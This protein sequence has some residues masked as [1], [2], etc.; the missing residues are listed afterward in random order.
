MR[1][2]L[3][4]AAAV[5]LAAVLP[6]AGDR[7]SGWTAPADI[8]P[9]EKGACAFL[10][11][12]DSEMLRQGE[13][14]QRSGDCRAAARFYLFYLSRNPRDS[15]VLYNLACCYAR[16]GQA[17]T[18]VQVLR[19]ALG[20]GFAELALLER[21]PDFTSVR[22]T[23]EFRALVADLPAKS[24]LSGAALW[25]Q[26]PRLVQCR[27]ALPPGYS[28]SRPCPLVIGLHGNGGNGRDFLALM[29]PFLRAGMICVA[30]D[31]PYERPEMAGY[32]A[33]FTWFLPVQDKAVWAVADPLSETYIVNAAETFAKRFHA[34][35][36]YLL[37]FSQGA[38]AAI[39]TGVHHWRKFAGVACFGGVSLHESLS[40]TD[41][42]A[43]SR[44]R[45]FIGHG[46]ADAVSAVA[47]GRA[48]QRALS[49]AGLDVRYREFD[50]GHEVPRRLLDE[51]IEWMGRGGQR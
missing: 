9:L 41:I 23:R 11:R 30:P 8:D 22:D 16:L 32:G 12:D 46:N 36:V 44:L 13:T 47:N 4:L 48:N 49:A 7:V 5:L 19:H 28:A 25:V 3:F 2:S 1:R 17:A 39:D 34:S 35:A 21:D 37:G 6:S 15:R 38:S 51:V 40:P 42:A 27:Y 20:A 50:G 43:A 29:A 45:V 24:E 18:A 14:A 26:S 10:D 31:G 33:H